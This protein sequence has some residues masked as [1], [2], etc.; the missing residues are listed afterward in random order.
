MLTELVRLTDDNLLIW[1]S[2]EDPNKIKNLDY[3]STNLFLQLIIKFDD[4]E[5]SCWLAETKE[6][7]N[8]G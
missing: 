4:L 3:E 8:A 7:A 6:F 2:F 1:K 5:L